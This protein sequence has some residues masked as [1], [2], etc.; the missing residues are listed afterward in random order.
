MTVIVQ[1]IPGFEGWYEAGS[2]GSIFSVAR[3]VPR[4]DQFYTV[5]RRKLSPRMINA[6]YLAVH[7]RKDGRS[8]FRLVHRL[9]LSAFV[10]APDGKLF[11]NHKSGVKTDNQLSNLEWCDQS[12]NT[13]HSYQVLGR[14]P[15]PGMKGADNPSAKAVR[16]MNIETGLELRF[17]SLMDAVRAGFKASGIS[18]CANGKQKSHRNLI[19]SFT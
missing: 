12:E 4:G 8:D 11:V 1:P 2:D 10:A 18:A 3:S 17:G 16:A 19:W 13:V 15:T 14:R 9:V 5:Q 7:L 6:G